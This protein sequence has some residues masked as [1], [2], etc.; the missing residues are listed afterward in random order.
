[1]TYDG[2][3][4]PRVEALCDLPAAPSRSYGLGL[5]SFG[6]G[7]D[8]ELYL[9]QLGDRGRIYRLARTGPAVASIPRRL[10]EE[11]GGI[12]RS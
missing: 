2:A 4:P 11:T 9:C 3:G 6:E 7:C 1:M 8:G 5:S 12:S 10:S